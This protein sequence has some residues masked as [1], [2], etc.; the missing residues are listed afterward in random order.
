MTTALEGADWS[1]RVGFLGTLDPPGHRRLLVLRAF[2]HG[3]VGG[4]LER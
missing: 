1:A 4:E 3:I 2:Y